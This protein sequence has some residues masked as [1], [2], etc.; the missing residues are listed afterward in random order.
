MRVRILVLLAGLLVEQLLENSAQ[1]MDLEQRLLVCALAVDRES[2]RVRHQLVQPLL[3]LH[4]VLQLLLRL[5]GQSL[6]L[7][8]ASTDLSELIKVHL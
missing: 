8:V 3:Q 5:V 1:I 7:L 2:I 6:L 4:L